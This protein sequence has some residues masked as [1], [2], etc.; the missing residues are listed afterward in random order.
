MKRIFKILF[1]FV[2]VFGIYESV[3][4]SC[5]L[6]YGA[7]NSSLSNITAL[8]EDV[9]SATQTNNCGPYFSFKDYKTVLFVHLIADGGGGYV[10]QFNIGKGGIEYYDDKNV[11]WIDTAICPSYLFE[12]SEKHTDSQG[13]VSIYKNGKNDNGFFYQKHAKTCTYGSDKHLVYDTVDGKNYLYFAGSFTSHTHKQYAPIV[14]QDSIDFWFGDTS[15]IT[16]DVDSK[17]LD[18]LKNFNI[19]A[20]PP[21]Y[22]VNNTNNEAGREYYIFP[23]Q[24]LA[25]YYREK[26]WNDNREI[27][28][29]SNGSTADFQNY[30]TSYAAFY[31]WEEGNYKVCPDN[32]S[33]CVSRFSHCNE[34]KACLQKEYYDFLK[35]VDDMSVFCND[36]YS[37]CN[38]SNGATK[39][40]L[41]IDEEI[42]KIKAKYG[43]AS[44]ASCG[45]S[46]RIIKWLANIVKWV[47]YIAP[48]LVI[49]LG[50]LDFI[51]AFA[52]GNDDEM[53]KVKARFVKRLISAALLFI[54][55]FIIEFV[56]DVF[57]LV[58]DNPYCNLF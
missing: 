56:L 55:P 29:I 42:S 6:E 11:G 58:T 46:D 3:Y 27:V 1:V 30:S 34:D 22:Q 23:T 52:S 57:N 38:Y 53:K 4:A 50:I 9:T 31:K 14:F 33:N 25:E 35:L 44:V 13:T 10:R 37:S 48:V 12:T 32:D 47:K 26:N 16:S 7:S 36:V 51:K 21:L 39:Y 49:I 19:E 5:N 18:D 43:K 20:C 41:D 54:V 24:S 45:M 17:I 8:E 15:K 2:I 28:K 40:C